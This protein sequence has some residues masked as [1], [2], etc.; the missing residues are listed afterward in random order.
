MCSVEGTC[1]RHSIG[2]R[3]HCSGMEGQGEHQLAET[4]LRRCPSLTDSLTY[5][6]DTQ[7]SNSD[8]C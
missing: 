6:D 5:P 7:A 1:S 2:C 4:S 3:D 8:D